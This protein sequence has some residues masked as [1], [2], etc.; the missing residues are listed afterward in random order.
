MIL[1]PELATGHLETAPDGMLLF[2]S[3]GCVV[4]ANSAAEELFGYTEFGL[5]GRTMHDLVPERFR[6]S[7]DAAH[8][9]YVQDP[10]PR[11]MGAGPD[12]LVALRQDGTEF[13][14][15]ISLG[16]LASGDGDL[17]VLATVR[18]VTLLRNQQSESQA[19]RASLD[20][21]EEAVYMFEVGS[22]KL[23]YVND[24]ACKQS[25]LTRAEL[26]DDFS[27]TDLAPGFG[28][29]DLEDILA[30]VLAGD[31]SLIT[32]DS[33]HSRRGAGDRNVEVLI[34]HPDASTF[35]KDCMIALVRDTTER[36]EQ[37]RRLSTSERAFRSA[38]ED[39]PVGMAI[40]DLSVPGTRTILAANQSLADMLERTVE[41]LIGES[42]DVL[43]HPED[44]EASTLGAVGLSTGRLNLYRT[45]KRYLRADGGVVTAFLSAASLAGDEGPRTL[46]HIVDMSRI[47]EAETERDQREELLTFLG[48]I[49][50]AVLADR[51]LDDVLNFIVQTAIESLG[52][53]HSLIAMPDSFGDLRVS[54]IG[55]EIGL[56]DIGHKIA[57]SS[58]EAVAFAS[59]EKL[60]VEN[61]SLRTGLSP[62]AKERYGQVGSAIF[63]P[64]LSHTKP[65]GVLFVGRPTGFASFSDDE[66]RFVEALSSESAL[67]LQFQIARDQRVRLG[68]AEERE[69]IAAELQDRVI[70]RLFAAGMQLQAAGGEHGR[71]TTAAED[72]VGEIDSCISIIRDTVFNLESRSRNS[73][74]P[75]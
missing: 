50:L 30:P 7:H 67:A 11:Y 20:S 73:I 44:R 21:V 56:V 38:F 5:V 61:L 9:D 70:Q 12:S 31:R 69:R 17:S 75:S 46:A 49:R 13:P 4:W 19:I 42:F 71:L 48:E 39:A 72:V 41:E 54:A 28:R 2:D 40:A 68:L 65:E 33:V 55:G 22:F 57:E 66:I 63:A 15:E 62:S 60:V 74:G 3:A 29:Q 43:T 45:Q 32:F 1:T 25:G 14:V 8:A 64:L 37:I 51:P 35:G 18:D 52:A 36:L 59:G 58:L 47:L 34:Q 27:F 10:R 6:A 24:G 23:C 26:L 53:V 16:P